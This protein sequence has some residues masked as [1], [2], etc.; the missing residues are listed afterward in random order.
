MNEAFPA[1]PDT[2]GNIGTSVSSLLPRLIVIFTVWLDAVV[3]PFIVIGNAASLRTS[4][5]AVLYAFHYLTVFLT[6]YTGAKERQRF[7]SRGFQRA[8]NSERVCVVQKIRGGIS[9]PFLLPCA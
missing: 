8:V 7:V 3:T 4:Q 1:L 9:L 5:G 2:L 6:Q